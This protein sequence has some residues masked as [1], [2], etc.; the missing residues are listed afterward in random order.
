MKLIL[1]SRDELMSIDLS[2]IP[3]IMTSTILLM[4]FLTCRGISFT[5]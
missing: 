4:V 1:N 3:M 2:H 5:R